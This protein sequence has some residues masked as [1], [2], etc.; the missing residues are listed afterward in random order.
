M[1]NFNRQI[2]YKEKNYIPE[3][4]D[5]ILK[6]FFEKTSKKYNKNSS[7]EEDD[8][9]NDENFKY[10]KITISSLNA[11]F[12][13]KKKI[14]RKIRNKEFNEPKLK[15][16]LEFHLEL[17]KEM[18]NLEINHSFNLTKNHL[19][20]ISEFSQKKPFKIVELDKNIG[21]ALISNEL[22][23]RLVLK[24]LNDINVYSNF[25]ENPLNNIKI[26]IE[27]ELVESLND[28]Q[29]SKKLFNNLINLGS[30]LG[31]FRI[32]PKILKE[33]FDT[34]PIINYRDHL[35][36]NLCLFI[37]FLLRPYVRKSDSFIMDSQNLIQKLEKMKFPKDSEITTGDFKS[38]FSNINHIDCLNLLTEFMTDKLKS[39]EIKISGFRKILKLI[40]ENNYFTFNDR[41]FKQNLGV[42]MGCICGPTIANIFVY[43][44]E[45]KWI[46]IHKPLAYFRFV[47]DILLITKDL[48][49]L[50]SLKNAFGSLTLNLVISKRQV[51]LDLE[52]ELDKITCKITFFVYFKPTNTFSYL[53]IESNHPT[54]IFKN[55]I[56]ALF[57]R[58]RRICTFLCDYL[59]FSNIISN[60]LLKRGYDKSLI[61]KNLT[62]V[63]NIKRDSLL[64]YKPKK[65]EIDFEKSFIFKYEFNK[66][67]SNFKEIIKKAFNSF[68][69]N[70][71]KYRDHN[72]FLVNKMQNNLSSILIH[73]FKYPKIYKNRYKKC[74]VKNCKTCEFSNNRT[75]INLTNNFILPISENTSCN[76][77]N[78]IYIIFCS[79]CN[80]FYLGQSNCLKDRIYSH[81]YD[82]RKFKYPFKE[83]KSVAVHFNL[84]YHDYKKHFSFFVLR[85]DL[86]NRLI[87][88]SFLINLCK[89][90]EV[91]LMNDHI[92]E[93]KDYYST[94]KLKINI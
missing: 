17:L 52:L 45:K 35:I 91:R 36:T 50:E 53:Y 71:T 48:L 86:D 11:F 25:I 59:Y 49:C 76:S 74:L 39:K 93:I 72:I 84:K 5:I 22:Y 44:Y 64:E 29:I 85:K 55:L 9:S 34:R 94:N 56:K 3:N 69:E 15:E 88:E 30:R 4:E 13:E 65:Q 62:M 12:E 79:F 8:N 66:N 46:T 51:F 78:V 21:S 92:P 81:I 77:K 31:S 32:L 43:I 40:L 73:N 82:I 63:A 23:E 28:S 6:D 10:E 54:H 14:N 47:D 2:F 27:S 80:T 18:N 38:L 33:K 42:A 57:I 1:N 20:V 37:E 70:H 68:K 41:Y 90:L 19:K 83:F 67:I 87:I 58:I 24:S 89:K 61:W 26:N 75:F 7:D 60:R 16:S